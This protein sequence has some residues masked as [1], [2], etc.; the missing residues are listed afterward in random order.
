MRMRTLGYILLLF[1]IFSM[2]PLSRSLSLGAV[3][4]YDDVTT[5][6]TSIQLKVLTKGMIF[7]EGGRRVNVY[8][9]A[10]QVGTLLTGG[11][12]FGYWTHRFQWS[13]SKGL[14]PIPATT[15]GMD[16]S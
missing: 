13:D 6:G 7:R 11:D 10:K 9:G 3:I 8:V 1:L 4:V 14:W 12:G 2:L 16:W 15:R 5:V